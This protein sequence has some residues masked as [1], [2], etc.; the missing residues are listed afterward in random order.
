MDAF[1]DFLAGNYPHISNA[2]LSR[3]DFASRQDWTLQVSF[4]LFPLLEPLLDYEIKSLLDDP[5]ILRDSV[6]IQM[7]CLYFE[8]YV[9]VGAIMWR[10]V[11][12]ELRGLTNSK[13]LELNPM[14]LNRY[15]SPYLACYTN[16][17]PLPALHRH[18][19]PTGFTS[20]CMML[21][22]NCKWIKVFLSLSFNFALGHIYIKIEADLKS[23]TRLWTGIWSVTCG[24]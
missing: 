17:N 18:A 22:S 14:A 6:L 23:S 5:N 24:V 8:A 11:F 12:R 15:S 4:E 20:T 9:H 13:G 2:G 21:G 19:P 1:S 16:R 3:A 7:K 10:V